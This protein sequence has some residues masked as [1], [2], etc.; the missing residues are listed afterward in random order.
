MFAAVFVF[1]NLWWSQHGMIEQK[2]SKSH[3]S[4]CVHCFKALDGYC[5]AAVK[6]IGWTPYVLLLFSDRKLLYI[7]SHCL[8]YLFW[9]MFTLQYA[10][11][12]DK[13]YACAEATET[14][15]MGN[16]SMLP[17]TCGEVQ[18]VV[19]R[20]HVMFPSYH[21]LIGCRRYD[22]TVVLAEPNIL[23]FLLP[24][25]VVQQIMCL[26]KIQSKQFYV[27]SS[28]ICSFTETETEKEARAVDVSG[29][30]VGVDRSSSYIKTS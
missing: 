29:E 22:P 10:K 26:P 12:L 2:T 9:K 8:R 16:P 15:G 24:E 13:K 30:A 4:D 23:F 28:F 14:E 27:R 21:K 3:V 11:D 20:T 25:C 19:D 6:S 17:W 1:E 18:D 5:M 7:S